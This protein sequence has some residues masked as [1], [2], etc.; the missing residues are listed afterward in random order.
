MA[1]Q[2]THFE[3]HRSATQLWE[4]YK[5]TQETVIKA[6]LVL[7]ALSWATLIVLASLSLARKVNVLP[8]WTSATVII[9]T[10]CASSAWMRYHE[11]TGGY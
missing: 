5:P 6:S 3:V 8:D 10:L 9:S 11:R 1:T 2:S 4:K 7:G